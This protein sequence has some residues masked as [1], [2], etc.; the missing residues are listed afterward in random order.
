MKTS[1]GLLYTALIWS[2]KN[3]ALQPYWKV[4]VLL[5]ICAFKHSNKADTKQDIYLKYVILGNI[6]KIKSLLKI[7]VIQFTIPYSF[8][9]ILLL[10]NQ[11]S[12]MVNL[13]P[14]I[15]GASGQYLGLIQLKKYQI[16]AFSNS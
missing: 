16:R 15:V 6:A 2:T 3:F 11:R 9:I 8:C 14:T 12:E 10:K 7:S 5:K 13:K 1:K 4:F